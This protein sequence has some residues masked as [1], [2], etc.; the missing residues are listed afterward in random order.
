MLA[1]SRSL[2]KLAFPMTSA[3]LDL[4]VYRPIAKPREP[5]ADTEM[6]VKKKAK[7]EDF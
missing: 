3:R 6:A 5:K 7:R 4:N 1:V 2:L